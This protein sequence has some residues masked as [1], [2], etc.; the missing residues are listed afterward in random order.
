MAS[1]KSGAIS[2]FGV[3]MAHLT[4]GVPTTVVSSIKKATPLGILV[5]K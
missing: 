3:L 5:E 2:G 1:K 4:P